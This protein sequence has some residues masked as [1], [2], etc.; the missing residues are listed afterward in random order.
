MVAHANLSALVRHLREIR[1]REER[2]ETVRT[3][4]VPIHEEILGVRETRFSAWTGR[5][6]VAEQAM[7]VHALAPAALE[8]LER[9][10]QDEEL[11]RGNGGP[12]DVERDQALLQLRA[13]HG[14]LGDLLKL[15]TTERP[16]NDAIERI[17]MLRHEAKA[18]LVKIASATPVTGTVLLAF[19]A[20]A[21][22]ADLIVGNTIVSLAAGTLA[23]T[24]IKD[25]IL[26]DR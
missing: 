4:F 18:T 10:I 20:V 6:S 14:A 21:G 25:A 5:A 23:G 24:T 8:A 15:A 16:L 3:E 13:L 17:H 12:V 2:R 26:K 7:I 22:V 9:L 11:L 1:N 19:G